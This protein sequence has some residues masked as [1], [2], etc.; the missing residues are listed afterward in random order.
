MSTKKPTI[1][2]PSRELIKVIIFMLAMIAIT[3]CIVVLAVSCR[4]EKERKELETA[5]VEV[6]T[7]EPTTV[8]AKV[9]H[10]SAEYEEAGIDELYCIPVMMYHAIADMDNADT[11]YTGGNVDADGLTRT[12]EAFE[13][14]LERYYLWGYRCISLEDYVNGY[15]DVDFGYSPIVLTFDGGAEQAGLQGFDEE[16][17]PI[18]K[19]NSALAIME[20]FKE[21]HPDFNLTATF[22]LNKNLFGNGTDQDTQL[23]QWMVENG[24]DIASQGWS[25]LNFAGLEDDKLEEE[26]GQMYKFLS[27]IIPGE[28]VNIIAVS[29]DI[30]DASQYDLLFEGT[31][32]GFSYT[33]S[34]AVLQGETRDVSPFLNTFDKYNIQR[35]KAWDNGGEGNDITATFDELNGGKAYVSDGDADTIVV[36]SYD[37][38]YMGSTYGHETIQ[39]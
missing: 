36:H 35:V 13:T 22:F 14:D 3:V 20:A 21:E 10:T 7:Q 30:D 28:Y 17:N 33:S 4:K 16:G 2:K 15:I 24:Y 8:K 25:A 6:T 5:T 1:R 23:I 26:I 18:F 12:S 34:A 11:E 29:S 32:D 9:N 38:I 27:E 31:Y 37:S 19:N 39:Y